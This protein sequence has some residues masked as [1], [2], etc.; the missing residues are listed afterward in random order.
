M[1]WELSDDEKA[2]IDL[3]PPVLRC[4]ERKYRREVLPWF[5]EVDASGR[6]LLLFHG[7]PLSCHRVTVFPLKP[8]DKQP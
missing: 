3:R 6:C 2:E 1:P 5:G 4:D 8:D 7:R